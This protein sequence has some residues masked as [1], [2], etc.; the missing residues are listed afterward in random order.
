MRGRTCRRALMVGASRSVRPW[1]GHAVMPA[2]VPVDAHQALPATVTLDCPSASSSPSV[3]T[4]AR[5]GRFQE[6]RIHRS[7]RAQNRLQVD[8]R[9][10][11]SGHSAYEPVALESARPWLLSRHVVSRGAVRTRLPEA[12]WVSVYP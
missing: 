9:P 1:P 12:L 10:Y 3:A 8:R 5:V 2:G 4:L 7:V 6:H 11:R